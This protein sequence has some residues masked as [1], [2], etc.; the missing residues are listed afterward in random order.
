MRLVDKF[1][2][3]DVDLDDLHPLKTTHALLKLNLS[4]VFFYPLEEL[5]TK[6]MI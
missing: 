1:L 5:V 3:G 4:Y 2:A 6:A